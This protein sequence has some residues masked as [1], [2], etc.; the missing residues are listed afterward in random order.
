[1]VKS[2]AP[3]V[4]NVV[5]IDSNTGKEQK[6]LLEAS[7]ATIRIYARD[8]KKV[9][10]EHSYEKLVKWEPGEQGESG[11]RLSKRLDITVDSKAGTREIRL[12]ARTIAELKA[13]S[14]T[15]LK[16]AKAFASRAAQQQPSSEKKAQV[17]GV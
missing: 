6:V 13:I 17:R 10:E 2:K 12:Q 3:N 16:K 11:S 15:L 5:A 9:L 4:F 8:T 14:S 7:T 1:M